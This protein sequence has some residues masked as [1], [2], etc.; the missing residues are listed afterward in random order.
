M[1]LRIKRKQILL[2]TLFTL[3][4]LAASCL[5]GN[6]SDTNYAD[7]IIFGGLKRTYL[8]HIPPSHDKTK[9]MPL[10]IALHGGGG[11]GKNMVKLTMGGFDKLSDKKGF[12]VAYPDGIEKHWN[13]GRNG[14]ETGYRAHKE[15]IDDVGFI[16][17]LIDTLIKKLNIHP[18]RVYITGMSNG[19][20]MSYRLACE[21]TEKIAAIAPV[22]GN[23]PQN[24][25][26]S[27]SPSKPISVLAINNVNDPLMPFAGGNITGPV[28]F[29]KLGKV[30]S[31]SDTIRF[32]VNH[33]NCS[34]SP[35][36]TH[37]PDNNPEDGTWIQKEIYGN[38]KDGTE[39][40]LYAI[41]GGGH[42]WPG[43]Y[44]YLNEK[45]IGKTSRDIDANEV[46]WDF[47]EKHPAWPF[48][49]KEW[50]EKV[51]N[52][53]EY[54]NSGPY[55]VKFLEF[56]G[57]ED[58]GRKNRKV[59]LKV[60]F[61]AE[62]K[63]FPLVVFSHG[64]GGNW[65]SNIYQAQHLASHGYVV[66]CVEDVYSNNK[67]IKFYMR[68]GGGRIRYTEALF[69]TTHDPNAMLERPKDISFAI[70]QAILW[71]KDHKELAE[72]I[73]TEKIGVMGHSYGAYTT[74]V[75]CG[76]QPILDYLE[77]AVIPRKGLAGNFSDPR[78]T[79]GLAMSPQPPGGTFFSKDS[80]RTINRPLVGIS[81][82]ED[83]WKTFD[84]KVMPAENR[85]EFW[86]LLPQGDKYFLWLERAD[87]SSFSDSPKAWIL[88]SK[89]RL[90]VQRISKA[91]MVLFCDHFLKEKK[92]AKSK[93][94][95][96]YANS[97]CGNVVRKIQWHE[98]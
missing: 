47:F 75:A 60:H 23:L 59:P 57:L 67:R 35:V 28:G 74:L 19:A 14:K 44:P 17:A 88:P 91:M 94:N 83:T 43:G 92:E 27:C 68:N 38:G 32:W 81:G 12:V 31:T 9:S 46:I 66:I 82:S 41:T 52:K 39:V 25:Y 85:W 56:P 54:E 2:S 64:G 13:D 8:I 1:I 45:I 34:I 87:H 65:D 63:N 77:P 15:D 80:Y 37:E 36:I 78:V 16:S 89:S 22:A 4:L 97:L 33:N 62:G 73:N 53:T 26:P 70:D 5:N 86:D 30:L 51:G 71:N 49:N 6:T 93:M 69:R 61:P 18:K 90:D 11:T 95:G 21:L 48:L 40:I 84:D 55:E 96:G 10:L 20:I 29:K 42:T 7:S 50:S 98:K 24:L 79:F 58:A 76:A 3:V 72:K